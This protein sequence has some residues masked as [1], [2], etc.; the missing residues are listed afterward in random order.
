LHVTLKSRGQCL[1]SDNRLYVARAV[2]ALVLE[3]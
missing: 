3:A 1:T 2:V